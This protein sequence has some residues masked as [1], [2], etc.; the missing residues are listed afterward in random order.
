MVT[1]ESAKLLCEGSNPFRASM[2]NQEREPRQERSF[3]IARNLGVAVA[4]VS[5]VAGHLGV[6]LL[7]VFEAALAHYGRNL[8][9]RR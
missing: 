8:I 1:Q 5:T 2:A 3:E 6:A 9:R 7:A 4:V